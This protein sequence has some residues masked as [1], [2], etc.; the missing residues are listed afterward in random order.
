MRWQKKIMRQIFPH[1]SLLWNPGIQE[2]QGCLMDEKQPLTK[3]EK[4][5][6]LI[7]PT[8][9]PLTRFLEKEAKK[10]LLS[11]MK[12]SWYEMPRLHLASGPGVKSQSLSDL[13]QKG[14]S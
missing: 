7:S 11:H 13:L 2:V 1:D 10:N 12:Y 8:E 9:Q 4:H 5:T 3:M 14:R 6:S